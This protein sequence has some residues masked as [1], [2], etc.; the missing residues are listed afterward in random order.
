MKRLQIIALILTFAISSASF[1][2]SITNNDDRVQYKKTK[3]K[4]VPK[5]NK[6]EQQRKAKMKRIKKSQKTCVSTVPKKDP[7]FTK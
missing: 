1:S 5:E 7:L 2:A 4:N 6:V 3:W